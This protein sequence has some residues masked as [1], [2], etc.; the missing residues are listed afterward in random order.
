MEAYYIFE[1]VIGEDAAMLLP[2][3]YSSDNGSNTTSRDAPRIN[4][5]F[6]GAGLVR[7][8]AVILPG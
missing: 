8:V 7:D 4:G 5:G 2:R 6:A 1:N 3:N